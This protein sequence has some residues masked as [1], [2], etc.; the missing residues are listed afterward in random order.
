[1]IHLLIADGDEAEFVMTDK[2]LDLTAEDPAVIAQLATA[3]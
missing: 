1:M 3:D 2:R